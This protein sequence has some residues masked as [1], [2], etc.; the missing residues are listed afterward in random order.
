VMVELMKLRGV[1]ARENQPSPAPQLAM[2]TPM[3]ARSPLMIPI[4]NARIRIDNETLR[5]DQ[6]GDNLRF[7]GFAERTLT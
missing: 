6:A 5:L 7:A 1:P 4:R 2:A 3:R